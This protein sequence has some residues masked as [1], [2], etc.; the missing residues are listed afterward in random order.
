MRVLIVNTSEHTGGAAVAANRL[1]T[2]LRKNGMKVKMFVRDK[3]SD[4]IN[5]VRAEGK[6]RQKV[7][8]LFERLC[9]WLTNGLSRTNLFAIDIANCGG[10]ITRT[11]EFKEADIIHLHWVNQGMLSLSVLRRILRSGKPVV[12]T[13]HDLWPVTSICHYTRDCERFHSECRECTYLRF[14]G[15]H[16]LSHRVFRQKQSIYKE[17]QI[18]F[19]ACSQWLRREAEKSSLICGHT[20]TNIPNTID[21][22]IFCRQDKKGARKHLGLPLDKHIILFCC[23]RVTDE[24]KGFKEFTQCCRALAKKRSDIAVAVMGSHAEEACALI[25]FPTYQLGYIKGEAEAARVYSSADLFV[26]PSLEENLPNTIM[27][28]LACGTPCVGF[29]TGGIPEMI[30]HTENGYVARYRDADD[31][32]TGIDWCL[33]EGH[34]SSLSDAALSKVRRCYSQDAVA[35]QYINLYHS[36]SH[37]DD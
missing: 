15:E 11:K 5:V 4:D 34:Y 33:D 21:T 8:F 10:D 6:W 13:L 22:S 30:D 17:G 35:T 26:I 12:W 16:D 32:A 31:L 29:D 19:V 9:I 28:A 1:M 20:V 23:V 3:T 7:C 27:E 18:S 2:A 24:R 36:L 25:P 37:A 14:P